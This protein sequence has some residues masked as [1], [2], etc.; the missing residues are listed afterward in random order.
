MP[1]FTRCLIANRGEIALR[2]IRACRELGIQTVAVYSDADADSLPVQQA[3]RAIPIGPPQ[4]TA[5]YLNSARIVEAALQSGCDCLHPGFGFLAENADFAATVRAAGVTFIGPSAAAIRAMGLKT[6]A[7]NRV[8]AA[9]VPTLP[10]DQASR[11]PDEYLAAAARIGYP[12]LVK[13]VAGG[14]G[15][16]MRIVLEESELLS[17]IEAASREAGRA[18]ADSRIFLEKYI[19]DA[20]HIEFQVFGDDHGNTVHLFERECSI[21]RRH[22]KIIEEAPSPYLSMRPAL[23][24]AMAA[25]AVAAARSVGYTNAGTVEFIVDDATGAFYFLEMN[26]RLQVEHP[27]TELTTGRDLVHLQFHVAAGQP[28]PFTQADV[29]QIG[30]AIECR[31]Y[32]EDPAAGFLPSTGTLTLLHEPH[33]P[34]L[35]IDSGVRAGDPI[36]LYYDPMIAK[37]IAHASDRPAAIA[38]LQAALSSYAIGGVTTNISFL[39]DVLASGP[40]TSGQTT[41]NLIER[42]FAQWQPAESAP[43]PAALIAAALLS[44]TAAT[45]VPP[46]ADIGSDPYSPWA[47]LDSYRIGG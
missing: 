45:S 26:T 30:H 14:G 11:S 32:A 20:R 44:L 35:R 28:L 17:S 38:R 39:R 19:S 15:K 12:V 40:Y 33:G 7:L 4:P 29:A 6:E 5:S 31:I 21:Q 16:G 18:F 13:A 36:S 3:D 25:A 22:Q 23:R 27:V 43:P 8:R 2:L 9:G 47:R 34:G 37:L 41:T 42:Y 24:Q 46:T 10:G 1:Y